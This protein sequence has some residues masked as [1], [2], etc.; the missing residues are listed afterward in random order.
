MLF[1]SPAWIEPTVTTA[2]SRGIDLARDD[3]L[4]PHDGGRGHHDG[5]DRGVRAR[6]VAAAT[7]ERDG[8][9]VGCRHLGAGAHADRAGRKRG[10]VLAEHDVRAGE[11]VEHAV[12]DHRLGALAVLLGGLEHRDDGARPRVPIGDEP[13]ERAQHRGDVHV[14]AARVH[15]RHIETR[16]VGAARGARVVEAGALGDREGVGVGAQ[17]HHGTGLGV[18]A[19][20]ADDRGDPGPPDARLELDAERGQMRRDDAR[21]AGLLERELRMPVQIGVDG[22]EVERHGPSLPRRSASPS[23]GRSGRSNRGR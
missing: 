11:A 7:E 13:L 15:D 6:A 9:A 14:V 18:G 4:Q 8:E 23:A 2:T 1:L 12:G 22:F 19:R 20:V 16:G 17:P 10:D 21:G 3:R 5:V